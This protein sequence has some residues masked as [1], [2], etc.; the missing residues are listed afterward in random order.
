MSQNVKGPRFLT[1][2]AFRGILGCFTAAVSDDMPY[3]RARTWA[4][5]GAVFRIL[6]GFTPAQVRKALDLLQLHE[7]GV[8]VDFSGQEW[9]EQGIRHA[10]LPLSL[11][12][13]PKLATDAVVKAALDLNAGAADVIGATA[14]VLAISE[15]DLRRMMNCSGPDAAP[16]PQQAKA[17]SLSARTLEMEKAAILETLNHCNGDMG[18]AAWLLDISKKLLLQKMKRYG[19][20]VNS[21]TPQD[22]DR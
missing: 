8:A 9:D 16:A 19:I 20:E 17:W 11:K 10:H 22:Y 7:E 6:F 5:S 12:E 18:E 1:T 3:D 13:A 2:G 4:D 15:D 21:P 14:I